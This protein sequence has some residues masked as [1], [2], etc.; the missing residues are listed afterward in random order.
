M[1]C[2][3]NLVCEWFKFKSIY[4]LPEVLPVENGNCGDLKIN[5]IYTCCI[6]GISGYVDYIL[7]AGES[8]YHPSVVGYLDLPLTDC[9]KITPNETNSSDHLPLSCLISFTY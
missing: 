1:Y 2:C 8:K 6:D 3:F 9:P 7:M 4:Q 5:N